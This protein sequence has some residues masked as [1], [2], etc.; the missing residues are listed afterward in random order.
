MAA[1]SLRASL[2]RTALLWGAGFLA[3]SLFVILNKDLA[4][5]LRYLALGL[6]QGAIIALLAVGYSM[7]YG[8]IQLINFAHGEV[9]MF[10]TYF[11]LMFL[12]PTGSHDIF[13][14]KVVSATVGLLVACAIWVA[15]SGLLQSRW[16]RLLVAIGAGVA[17]AVAN[18]YLLPKTGGR[19][20]MPFFAAIAIAVV[21][22][23]CLGVTMDLLAYRPL[24]NSPRLI[25]LITAIGI[26]LFLQSYAQSI[27]GSAS[28]D[29]PANARPHLF[30]HYEHASHTSIPIQ[31]P[32]MIKLFS[33]QGRNGEP[34]IIQM[35]LL[36]LTIIMTAIVLLVALQLFIHHTRTGK[37]MRACAQDRIT[38]SL[39]G[40]QVNRV[41][42]LAFALG[43]GLAAIVAPLYVLRGTFI[44][45][46]MGYIVGIL[47]FASAVLGGIG[48]ISGAMLGGLIIGTIYSFVP[49][50]D[51]FDTFRIFG[52]LERW[53][54]LTEE[55][56]NRMGTNLGRPGQYQLGVAY[57]FMILVIVF[58]PTGLLGKASAKRA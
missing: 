25:P 4:T 1:V 47:A 8:I 43:A 33:A 10:S 16:L 19:N 42:A 22:S 57:A 56:W 54:W 58:K 40:I 52:T 55:G 18:F 3:F 12:V 21:Y 34:T 46:T 2:V 48:N 26:S 44:I 45:P 49:L 31:Q 41:V 9:F 13:S 23:C 20:P 36:D 17:F 24:R 11:T 37:A 51:S 15:V 39:M 6:P 35:P 7:V 28:R 32:A 50:F 5:Y 27:W 38:A 14:M 29:F 53:G 30:W